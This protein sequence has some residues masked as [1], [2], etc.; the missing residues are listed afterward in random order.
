MKR[1]LFT[2][3]ALMAVM[4]CSAQIKGKVQ[5]IDSEQFAEKIG[6]VLE[7]DTS[8]HFVGKRPAVVDFN[9]VWC[10][11]CRKLTPILAELA[12]Q[13]K[14]KV[15]FYSIDV[16]KNKAL[17]QMLQIRSIPHLVFFPKK[18]SPK[19][20]TGLYPKEVLAKKINEILL[21]K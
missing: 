16:D 7:N 4:C 19:T 20:L 5:E 13:Y 21:G 2:L 1:T 12:K 17:A 8:F 15:D 6:I 11:P 3:V 18:G 14:G 10:G 9:A